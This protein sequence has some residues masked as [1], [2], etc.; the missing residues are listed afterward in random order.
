MNLGIQSYGIKTFVKCDN[1]VLKKDNRYMQDKQ[2]ETIKEIDD[3]RKKMLEQKLEAF[4]LL[5]PIWCRLTAKYVCF[6]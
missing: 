3:Q 4:R 1:N 2:K 5:Y 6:L